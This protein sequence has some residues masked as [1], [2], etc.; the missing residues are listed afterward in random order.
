MFPQRGEEGGDDS[1]E[2]SDVDGDDKADFVGIK[3]DDGGEAVVVHEDNDNEDDEVA[4][5][6]VFDVIFVKD[7]STR[8]GSSMIETGDLVSVLVGAQLL[9]LVVVVV[10]VVVVRTGV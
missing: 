7:G 2:D 1:D 10:V 3:R 6:D 9:L 8:L 5:D 4:V